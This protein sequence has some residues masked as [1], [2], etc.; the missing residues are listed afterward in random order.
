MGSK[1]SSSFV[2][3]WQNFEVDAAV[4][5]ADFDRRVQHS[6][7][8]VVRNFPLKGCNVRSRPSHVHLL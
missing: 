5:V 2:G 4:L 3:Y 1:K 7:V 8:Y 6:F